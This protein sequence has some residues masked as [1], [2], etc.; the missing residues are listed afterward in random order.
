MWFGKIS[1]L[2]HESD[3]SQEKPILKT[4]L[5]VPPTRDTQLDQ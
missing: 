4:A 2:A 3:I 5:N 1:F